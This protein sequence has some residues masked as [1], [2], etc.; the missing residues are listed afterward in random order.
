M[1]GK[2]NGVPIIYMWILLGSKFLFHCKQSIMTVLKLYISILLIVIANQLYSQNEYRMFYKQPAKNWNEAI[3]LGN[4][5][6]GAMVFGGVEQEH[7]QFNEETLWTGKPRLYA[8]KGA[9]K[10]LDEIR[11]LLFE[12]KRR[13]A[14]AI[15]EKDFMSTPRSLMSYQPFGDLIINFPDHKEF[16][17][18]E[19]ELDIKNA[20]SKV[21]YHVNGVKYT[22]EVFISAPDQLMAI[23]LYSEKEGN[24]DF[25]LFLD[26]R[27]LKKSIV[28]EDG[29]QTLLV[30]PDDEPQRFFPAYPE[31]S[32]LQGHAGLKVITDGNLETNYKSISIS[33]ASSATIY[34]AAHTN[35][36]NFR[37]VSGKPAREVKSSLDKFSDLDYLTVKKN[38]IKDYQ[39]FYN[40]FNINFK[41]SDK[42]DIPTDQRIL[43]FWKDPDD[44]DLL[45]MYVQF[46]RYLLI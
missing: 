44:P 3:P 38:H 7:I 46:G 30:K 16:T 39:S 22:R 9:H 34:L 27:H 14:A 21:S 28:T 11:K 23:H 13:E 12:G 37:D 25:N 6:L 20:I 17:N 43:Q 29:T 36:V 32:V 19:R 18:Y 1:K 2:K 33:N 40:R 10:H 24:L 4:G 8:R 41:G 42:K 15:M 35:F 5:R 45:A 31:E 26:S